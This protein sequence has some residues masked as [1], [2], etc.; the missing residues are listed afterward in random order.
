MFQALRGGIRKFVS[1]ILRRDYNYRIAYGK[2][3]LEKNHWSI[4]GAVS[5]EE[6][7]AL[8]AKKRE[9][10][11][12]HGLTPSSRVLDV[13]CGT[14][15]LAAALEDY[16]S[17]AAL[18]VGTDIAE[19]AVSSCQKKF[20]RPNFRFVRN[21]MTGVPVASEA[22]DFMFF[23]SVFTHMYPPEVTAMLR[24]VGRLLDPQG[25][26]IADAFFSSGIGTWRG[27][28]GM[29]VIDEGLLLQCFRA[30]GYVHEVIDD[31]PWEPGVRRAVF[32]LRREIH[33]NG[34][35]GEAN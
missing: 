5:A 1:R 27:N 24:D 20:Q 17:P 2:A 25:S 18:Y 28:R 15:Q 32:Q 35:S 21:D 7:A 26:I 34:D 31:K 3:D 12:A 13:G 9:L 6:W 14:G 30:A 10:L 16:L 11:V 23:G 22:F 19:E 4:V 8:G 33:A 29:V